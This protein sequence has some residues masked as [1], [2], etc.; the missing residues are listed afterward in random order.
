MKKYNLTSTAIK[1]REC[2]NYEDYENHLLIPHEAI[3]RE[4]AKLVSAVKHLEVSTFRFQVKALNKW[5]ID[6]YVPI[7]HEHH[8]IEENISFPYWAKLG[9]AVPNDQIEDHKILLSLISD[10]SKCIGEA[11]TMEEG[12]LDII[13][14]LQSKISH[15]SEVL[16]KHLADEESHWSELWKKHTAKELARDEQNIVN[17]GLS[18]SGQEGEA[19][20]MNF[21]SIM[22]SMGIDTL[23]L[24]NT[25][26]QWC[27]DEYRTR[28]Y[29]NTPW[30][31]RKLVFP[32]WFK[33]YIRWHSLI[34]AV[35][36]KD[37]VYDTLF[38]QNNAGCHVSC[39]IS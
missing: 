8:H 24:E 38:Q 7:I 2:G 17:H 6:F 1:P 10:T 35:A 26:Y 36:N 37:D 28:F 29:N 20:K 39:A 22:S 23:K 34:I 12:S 32:S 18:L 15:F 3:R 5:W 16:L 27:S 21:A 9:N 4:N 30:V 25:E 33:R 13:K 19:F 14:L 31:A 11:N